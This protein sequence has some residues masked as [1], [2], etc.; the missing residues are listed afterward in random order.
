MSKKNTSKITVEEMNK[1][2]ANHPKPRIPFWVKD[3]DVEKLYGVINYT[4]DDELKTFVV[5]GYEG[6]KN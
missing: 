6:P 5:A 4:W 3:E 2:M 1:M